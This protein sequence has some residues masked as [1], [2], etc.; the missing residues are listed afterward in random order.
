MNG[1]KPWLVCG[2]VAFSA[3]LSAWSAWAM[4][5]RANTFDAVATAR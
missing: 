2:Y 4:E 1:G 5:R 3:L